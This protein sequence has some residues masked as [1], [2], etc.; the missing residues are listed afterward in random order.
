MDTLRKDLE[1]S[2]ARE[3]RLRYLK[4]EAVALLDRVEL[5]GDDFPFC[6]DMFQPGPD[7]EDWRVAVLSNRRQRKELAAEE[8]AAVV[9]RREHSAQIAEAAHRSVHG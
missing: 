2:L 7:F 1:S 3:G 9:L 8:A 5:P 4:S 6:I